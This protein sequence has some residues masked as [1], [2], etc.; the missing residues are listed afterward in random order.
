MACACFYLNHDGCDPL[1]CPDGQGFLPSQECTCAATETVKAEYPD[2]AT[3]EQ[4]TIAYEHGKENWEAN[5]AAAEAAA[6]AIGV[7]DTED[8]STADDADADADTA[9]DDGVTKPDEWP[10][11]D[12]SLTCSDEA[13]YLN[14]LACKCFTKTHCQDT[15]CADGE[16]LIPTEFC[17]CATFADIKALYPD[18]V[19]GDD[20]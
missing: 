2:W 17:A 11:C 20:V 8:T 19:D 18:W 10:A 1:V 13:F 15:T 16:D 7:T 9:T 14:K 3:D 4:I 12:E 5:T 6:N